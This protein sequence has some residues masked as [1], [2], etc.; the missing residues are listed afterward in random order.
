MLEH[1]RG[2]HR[3]DFVCG[4][5]CNRGACVISAIEP[6]PSNCSQ[7][8]E[9]FGVYRKCDGCDLVGVVPPLLRVKKLNQPDQRPST[10]WI[11]RSRD[12]ETLLCQW[13]HLGRPCHISK[14]NQSLQILGLYFQR[15][16]KGLFSLVDL[17]CS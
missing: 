5:E 2:I 6:H 14:P 11:D 3:R 15:G 16:L 9:I 1:N 12:F 10:T 13:K 7:Y 8:I 17:A 4:L